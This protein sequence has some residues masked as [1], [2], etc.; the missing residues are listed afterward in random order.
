MSHEVP[1]GR[2]RLIYLGDSVTFHPVGENYPTQVEQLIESRSGLEVETLNAAVPGFAA[3]NAR[4]LLEGD[5]APFEADALIVYLGWNDL[6]QFGPE[7]LP[8]K[9]LDQGYRVGPLGRV[10]TASYSVR[11]LYQLQRMVARRTSAFDAPLTPAEAALYGAHDPT[12]FRE[13]LRAIL[14]RGRERYPNV[15]VCTLAT[16][17]HP[18]PTADELARAHFPVGLGKNLRKLGRLVDTYNE[19][20]RGVAAEVDVGLIDLHAVFDNP[21]ARAEL[22]DSC[23]VGAK[24]AQRIAEA[25]AS[26]V[27]RAVVDREATHRRTAPAERRPPVAGRGTPAS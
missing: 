25:V 13:H 9:R 15:W 20:V 22:S 7:G 21:A 23:H 10:L 1:A 17:T 18:D 26:R 6:G 16:L 19:I 11:L 14:R 2:V 5:L 8:Y 27:S 4:A 3:H 12:H 24:G